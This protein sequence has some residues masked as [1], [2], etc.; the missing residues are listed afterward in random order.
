MKTRKHYKKRGGTIDMNYYA[1]L[2]KSK[3]DIDVD[4][5]KK[6]LDS[7]ENPLIHLYNF[8]GNGELYTINEYALIHGADV[9]V[10]SLF[11]NYPVN[12]EHLVRYNSLRPDKINILEA[13]ILHST[14]I[15]NVQYILEQIEST[16]NYQALFRYFRIGMHVPTV[17]MCAIEASKFKNSIFGNS[18]YQMV[19]ELYTRPRIY[20]YLSKGND[21]NVVMQL[22]TFATMFNKSDLIVKIY[23]FLTQNRKV[24]EGFNLL[25]DRDVVT[26]ILLHDDPQLYKTAIS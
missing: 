9:M 26:N 23:M 14:F 25:F 16:N 17:L 24:E 18:I 10:Q 3:K 11:N 8:D 12:L 21:N 2:M 4:M 20:S 19:V 1:S 5:F 7:I 13:Y 6:Y 15:L 22:F